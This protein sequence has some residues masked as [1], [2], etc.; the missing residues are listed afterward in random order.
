MP[1]RLDPHSYADLTQA[2]TGRVELDLLV[3]FA[4][5]TLAGTASL[6]FTAP[7]AGGPIDLDTRGLAITRVT[8]LGQQLLPFTLHPLEAGAEFLGQRLTVDAPAGTRGLIVTYRTSPDASALQW[9]NPEQTAGKKLPFLFSQCQAIH[10]RSV[11]PLQDT[12]L[13][14]VTYA[15]KL[16]V[17]K[18]LRALMGAGFLRRE[19]SAAQLSRDGLAGTLSGASATDVFEMPQ[20]IPPYLLA[21]AVGD[22]AKHD[23]TA[24]MAVW[25]EPSV[26]PKAA[27]EFEEIPEMMRAAEG[28]FGAYDW[29]RYDVLVMPPS[30]PYGGMENPRLTFAT[31]SLLAGDRSLVNVIAHELAHAWTGNLVTNA[32]ANDFWLNEG[33]TVYA[34]RRIV[35]AIAGRERSELQAALGRSHLADELG[36]F[37]SR[38]EMTRLRTSLWGVDPDDVYSSVPYEKGYLFLRRLEELAGREKFDAFLKGYLKRFRFQSITTDDF[39]D[40]LHKALPGVAHEANAAEWLDG[41]GLPGDAP[42]PH[43]PRLL[44]LRALSKQLGEGELPDAAELQSVALSPIELQL[45]LSELPAETSA[46]RCEAIEKLFELGKKQ[47]LELRVAWLEAA[48][49]AGTESALVP[50]RAVLLETGRMKFLKPLYRQLA[51]R[52]ETK[53]FARRVFAEASGGYHPIAKAGLEAMLK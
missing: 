51:R 42:L 48:L 19:E 18:E 24:R 15:A 26:L 34:E 17:P 40:E 46:L 22:L 38:P 21:F 5:R 43:A 33:F 28:L 1:K 14:R 50:A 9:L 6:V 25:A 41:Q 11:A 20:P 29:D 37:A 36:R 47:S 52:P 13:A 23:L 32:S 27:W 44:M 45:V 8:D 10:A 12:P 3:D 16:T 7:A 30:F 4:T 49:R 31:P 2:R 53:E 35:E 39:L